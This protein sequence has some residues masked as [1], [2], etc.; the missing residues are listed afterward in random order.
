MDTKNPTIRKLAKNH[1]RFRKMMQ[2]P[3][4]ERTEK[5]NCE[6]LRKIRW[7]CKAVISVVDAL[8]CTTTMANSKGWGRIFLRQSTMA[9]IDEAGAL[10]D[11]EV[12][13]PWRAGIPLIPCGDTRQLAPKVFSEGKKGKSGR[14]INPFA[15][16]LTITLWERLERLGW[17][18]LYLNEQLRIVAGAFDLANFL[19]Y[20]GKVCDGPQCELKISVLDETRYKR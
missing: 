15:P 1:E 19:V 20:L 10:T 8:F 16:R 17:P 3:W 5:M 18:I 9:V 6:L 7:A 12:L 2:T 14:L 4:R 11:A 13:I